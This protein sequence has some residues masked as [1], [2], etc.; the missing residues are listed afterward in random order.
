MT[1]TALDDG[2]F[3]ADVVAAPAAAR[4]RK[5]APRARTAAA[6]TPRRRRR[7]GAGMAWNPDNAFIFW[8]EVGLLFAAVAA[9]GVGSIDGLLHYATRIVQ[10]ELQWV[11]PVAVDI[12]LVGTALATLS[13]RR[14]RAYAAVVFCGAV[15]LALVL[16]SAAC[17][18]MYIAST[19]DLTVDLAAAA[20]PWIKAA[21]PVLLLAAIEIVAALTSTRNNR[22]ASPLNRARRELKKVRAENRRLRKG[23]DA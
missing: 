12:F 21:M 10:P 15:T 13:L 11:L 3:P 4:K 6:A 19:T 14:R 1:D 8:I 18:Y 23:A 5:R 20:A 9:A 22:E 17:N 2:L 16:F 7:T